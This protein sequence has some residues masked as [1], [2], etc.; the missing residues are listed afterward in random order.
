M[1]LCVEKWEHR[2]LIPRFV[3]VAKFAVNCVW[4]E[5]VAAAVYTKSS[6]A[7]GRVNIELVSNILLITPVFI[8]LKR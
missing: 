3:D 4:F 8:R 1:C 5:N 7:I 2:L 6:R